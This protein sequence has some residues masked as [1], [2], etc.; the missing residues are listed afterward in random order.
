MA[1]AIKIRKPYEKFEAAKS[2]NN[3]PSLC[4]QHHA[5]SCDINKIMGRYRKTGVVDHLNKHGP[6]YGEIPSLDLQEATEV[7]IKANEM[8][9]DLPSHIRNKFD[10][11]PG[12]FLDFVQNPANLEEMRELGLSKVEE[13]AVEQVVPE[14]P[15]APEEEVIPK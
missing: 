8:F 1:T 11:K 2:I 12:D 5:D 7:V 9:D 6:M 15:L 14:V 13:P 4:E 3:E 10:N